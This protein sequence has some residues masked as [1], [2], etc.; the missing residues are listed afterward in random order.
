MHS[1]SLVHQLKS[2]QEKEQTVLSVL[3]GCRDDSLAAHNNVAQS[4]LLYYKTIGSPT[5]R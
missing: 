4:S 2:K 3:P 5:H 1:I